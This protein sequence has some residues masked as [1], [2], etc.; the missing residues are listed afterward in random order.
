M[1]PALPRATAPRI[2]LAAVA[3]ALVVIAWLWLRPDPPPELAT[4]PATIAD[5]EQTVVAT[6]TIEA[7][8]LVSVGAQASGQI[9]TLYV[10]AGDEVKA[11]DPIAEIDS[12]TQENS[13]RNA[14]AALANMRAQRAAQVAQVVEAEANHERQRVM[15]AAEATAPADYDSAKAALAAARAQVQSIDAQIEQAQTTLSTARANLGYTRITAPIDGTVV[16]VV[17]TEGQTVNAGLSTPTIVKLA[18][19]DTMTINAEISEADVIRIKPGMEVWFTILGAPDTRYTATLRTVEPAPASIES[20]DGAASTTSQAVYYNA[21]FDVD[22]P[23]RV[24]RIAMTAQ[25][26]VVLASAEDVLT[27]PATALGERAGRD[28]YTVRVL[29]ADGRPEPRTIR[30]GINNNVSVQVLEGLQAGERVVVG[31]ASALPAGDRGTG[32]GMRGP[33]IMR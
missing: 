23:D 4:A 17:A 18:Q 5:I 12:T 22:N 27:I 14:E 13:L 8:E 15:L 24:L 3:L 29:G 11:G 33:R 26:N 9:K 25:V 19:L 6:G 7:R 2:A 31:E 1:K 21:L 32:R 20:D 10:E 30:T 28:G 16:A